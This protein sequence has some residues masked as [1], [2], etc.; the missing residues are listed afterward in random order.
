MAKMESARL[1]ELID[2]DNA[3][4][5]VVKEQLAHAS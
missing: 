5:S 2:A 3:W 1:A 4:A